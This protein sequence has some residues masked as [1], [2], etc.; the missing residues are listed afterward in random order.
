[1]KTKILNFIAKNHQFI[2]GFVWGCAIFAFINLYVSIVNVHQSI[3]RLNESIH[4]I[5]SLDIKK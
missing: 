5:D 4:K 1:M 2:S 3:N